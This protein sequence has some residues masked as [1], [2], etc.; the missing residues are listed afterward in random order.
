MANGIS[1]DDELSALL[2]DSNLNNRQDIWLWLHLHLHKGMDLDGNSCNGAS[3]RDVIAQ[4]LSCNPDLIPLIPFKKDEYLLPEESLSWITQNQRQYHWLRPRVDELTNKSV[5]L[6]FV[7]LTGRNHIIAMLD[8]WQ[9]GILEKASKIELL[10]DDWCR[11][12][13]RDIQFEWFKDK[14]EEPTRCRCAWEWIEK[15]HLHPFSNQR[16]I[17]NHQELLMF[18]DRANLQRYEQKVMIQEIKKRWNRQQFDER[19]ADKKQVNVMLSKAVIAHLDGLA[20][21]HDM[22]RA[23]V[24]EALVRKEVE[25]G[26]Y[27]AD[28]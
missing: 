28:A 14:K 6:D 25:I 27:L 23:Q 20:I 19:N 16:P 4:S 24:L 11:H 12:E 7:H 3:M 8:A 1:L 2:R 18:F 5:P 21:R 13:A 15:H 22:K 10:Q 9:V 17:T 26:E